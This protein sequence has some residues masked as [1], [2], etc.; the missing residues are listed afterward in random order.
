MQ[1]LQ[2]SR[3]Q[4]LFDAIFVRCDPSYLTQVSPLLALSTGAVVSEPLDRNL[5]ER[6]VWLDAVLNSVNPNVSLTLSSASTLLTKC[7]ERRNQR[8]R[9]QDHECDC[10]ASYHCV[11]RTQ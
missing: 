4:D 8:H 2:S 6:L 9:P 5:P 7:T 11:H 3:P 10:A 1:W